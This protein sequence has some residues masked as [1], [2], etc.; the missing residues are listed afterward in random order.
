MKASSRNGILVV[1]I[2]VL[3]YFSNI[4]D[5]VIVDANDVNGNDHEMEMII[6]ERKLKSCSRACKLRMMD[7][8]CDEICNVPECFY[9]GGDCVDEYFH[10][11]T[12]THRPT[13]KPT[14]QSP[15]TKTPTVRPTA[16]LPGYN[17]EIVTVGTMIDPVAQAFVKAKARWESI[18]KSDIPN[19]YT[20]KKGK[21]CYLAYT[22][23]D[24]D[25]VVDDLMIFAR[26]TSIDGPGGILGQAGPC[27][28]TKEPKLY[29]R[30]GIMEFDSADMQGLVDDGTVDAVILHE[31]GHILGIGTSWNKYK[32]IQ[33]PSGDSSDA[34]YLGEGGADGLKDIGGN[35]KPVIE[36]DGGRGTAYSHWDEKTYDNE[37]MTGYLGGDERLSLITVK[38][39]K[40]LGY[41]VDISKADAYKLPNNRE[42]LRANKRKYGNDILDIPIE[43]GEVTPY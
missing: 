14:T 20:Y 38:S 32:L 31:M 37:L 8:K 33:R 42:G 36:T 28:F 25:K 39:L 16:A 21:K 7:D 19:T 6:H 10:D 4:I 11:P 40:D 3:L 2:I 17:I 12:K 15:T 26:V 43:F 24:Q 27:V 1:I 5:N 29:P 9:D 30:V 23:L 18:V 13:F 22:V 35:G 34:Y 41:S